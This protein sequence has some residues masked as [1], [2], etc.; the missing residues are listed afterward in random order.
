VK[1]FKEVQEKEETYFDIHWDQSFLDVFKTVIKPLMEDAAK[2][3]VKMSVV[4]T[5]IDKEKADL[6][7]KETGVNAQ[8]LT[9]DEKFIKTIMR[10]NPG[11]VLWKDGVLL[12]K[13]HYK[14]LPKWDSI[15]ETYLK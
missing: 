2:D 8:Y 15:K 9:S 4:V 3:K 11:I 1:T 10:S 5:G 12:H 7:A 13:W 14:K 6:L